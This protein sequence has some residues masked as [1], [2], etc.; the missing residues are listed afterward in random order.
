MNFKLSKKYT[1]AHLIEPS[2]STPLF[3]FASSGICNAHSS[4]NE[5]FSVPPPPETQHNETKDNKN[6]EQG[7]R[8]DTGRWCMCGD[9]QGDRETDKDMEAHPEGGSG[10]N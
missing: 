7:A 5:I 4:G 3:S 8:K 10:L 6:K 1:V 9:T 2:F